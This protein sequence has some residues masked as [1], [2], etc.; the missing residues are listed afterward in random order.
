MRFANFNHEEVV[1]IN[2][3]SVRFIIGLL[4][5]A[6]LLSG[7]QI[8]FSLGTVK[9]YGDLAGWVYVS[10]NTRELMVLPHDNVP[11]GYRL[12]K[13]A[14]VT[15]KFRKS[16]NIERQVKTDGYGKFYFKDLAAGAKIVTIECLGISHK[17][18]LN[19]YI[20]WSTINALTSSKVYYIVV[21][22]D[23][24]PDISKAANLNVAVND[25]SAIKDVLCGQNDLGGTI[26]LLTDSDATKANIKKA[27]FDACYN[28]NKNDHLVFYFSGYADEEIWDG[29][30]GYANALDHLIP[31]DGVDGGEPDQ[32]RDSMITDGE[33]AGWLSRFP[34]QNNITVILDASYAETFIDG[35]VRSQSVPEIGLLALKA[36]GYTVLAAASTDERNLALQDVNS[37]FTMFLVEGLQN[38]RADYN[39]DSIITASE[40]Y[41]YVRVE[42]DYVRETNTD[43]D[44]I[45][46]YPR[47][48][49][50]GN[51]VV[52]VRY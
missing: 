6:M 1:I 7:C 38:L 42:M 2:Q 30:P 52:F 31:Y 32:I 11:S 17:L 29:L 3:R 45:V 13:D 39:N 43:P 19:V 40:L 12:L 20:Y 49:G 16:G 18:E 4:C 37:M 28:A 24:Y 21:G 36:P 26:E 51:S 33:L 48:S 47:I 10:D 34:N 46:P 9:R 44:I 25:A 41:D 50:D 14:E 5:A 22:I 15:V 8:T 23:E 27:I 35:E